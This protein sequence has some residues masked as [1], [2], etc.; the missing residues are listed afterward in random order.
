MVRNL[1][2]SLDNNPTILSRPAM[3]EKRL[4]YINQEVT[5]TIIAKFSIFISSMVLNL[6]VIQVLSVR[7]R[8]V[9]PQ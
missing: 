8:I 2:L 4:L 6:L 9:T 5:T 3:E 7:A 1:T